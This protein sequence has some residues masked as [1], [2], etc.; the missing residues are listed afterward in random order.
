M[1]KQKNET[2]KLSAEANAGR[3]LILIGIILQIL[4][5][6][7]VFSLFLLDYYGLTGVEKSG[8]IVL[9]TGFGSGNIIFIIGMI[10]IAGLIAGVYAY[11]AAERGD[12]HSAGILSIVSSFLP[13]LQLFMLAGGILCLVSGESERHPAK[14]I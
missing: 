2:K 4:G 14:K 3:M 10:Q 5:I 6:A 12:F 11:K 9:I 7:A 1:R 13:P 8:R